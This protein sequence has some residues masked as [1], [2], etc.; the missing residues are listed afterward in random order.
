MEARLS[1][2]LTMWEYDYVWIRLYVFVGI[3]LCG[4]MAMWE[5]NYLGVW[6]CLCGNSAMWEYGYVFVGIGLCGSMTMWKYD[7]VGVWLCGN[8]SMWGERSFH[9]IYLIEKPSLPSIV[10]HI[11]EEVKLKTQSLHVPRLYNQNV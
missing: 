8:N 1:G 3:H 11:W 6:L 2:S 4:S 10:F 5:Y 9:F 7:Y